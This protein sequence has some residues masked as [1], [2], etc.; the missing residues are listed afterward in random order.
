MRG[1]LFAGGLLDGEFVGRACPLAE[2]R[3]ATELAFG[4]L[5]RRGTLDRV[6]EACAGRRMEAVSAGLRDILRLGA[7]QLLFLDRVPA[8]AAVSESVELA[9]RHGPRGSEAFVN[10]V[11]REVQ[12]RGRA[13]LAAAAGG[14]PAARIAAVHSH[15][16]WLVER[17]IG[18]WGERETEALCAANNETPRVTVRA[19]ALRCDRDGLVARLA[20]EGVAAAPNPGHRLAADIGD[21]PGPIGDLAAFREGLFQV[22]DVAGMRVVDLLGARPGERVADLCAGPGGKATGIAES[23]GDGGEVVCVER[24]PGKADAIRRSAARLGL[25]SVKVTVGDALRAAAIVGPGTADRAVVDAPCSNTGVLRRRPE[26]RW[27]LGQADIARLADRQAAL[28]VAAAA[29][30][31]PGGTVLYSTC[32]IEPEE[33][34]EVVRR[35]LLE[36]EAFGLEGEMLFLPHRDG[37]D[38]GYAA[39]LVSRA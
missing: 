6:I 36:K 13:A 35:F 23:M 22:Q 27:R 34:E 31:R 18:R 8:Y 38:G 4:C 21:L 15:P 17:W 20:G 5:R 30:V 39:L 37:C 1:G 10:A 16:P 14:T 33:N 9:R 19:N 28:L 25:R 12:R 24:S 26:A 11:L 32:S 2:R 29:V 7:Y 3:L